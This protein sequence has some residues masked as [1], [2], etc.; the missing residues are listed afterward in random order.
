MRNDI[1]GLLAKHPN[2]KD[3]K[4]LGLLFGKPQAKGGS[5]SRNESYA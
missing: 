4:S 3:K 2:W 5:E 1:F